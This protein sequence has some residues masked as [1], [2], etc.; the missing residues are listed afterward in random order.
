MPPVPPVPDTGV[1]P[2]PDTGVIGV[3]VGVVGDVVGTVVTGLVVPVLE[4]LI[5]INKRRAIN[6]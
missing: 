4:E 2:V 6:M 3:E 5:Y 1:T